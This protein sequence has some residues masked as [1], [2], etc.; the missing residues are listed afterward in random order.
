MFGT[1]LML[2]I[3]LLPQ[4]LEGTRVISPAI[5]SL[6]VRLGAALPGLVTSLSN[7]TGPTDEAM[8]VLAGLKTEIGVLRDAGVLSPAKLAIADSLDSALTQA[9]AGYQFAEQQTDPSTLT[10]LPEVLA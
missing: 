8:S 9:L 5:G 6:I 1:I 4:I 10:D 3:N 2:V 7:G